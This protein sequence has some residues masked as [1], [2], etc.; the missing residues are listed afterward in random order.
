MDEHVI[1]HSSDD[2]EGAGYFYS[3]TENKS[4]LG[5][6]LI[7]MHYYDAGKEYPVFF[8]YYRKKDELAKWHKEEEFREKNEIARD[9]IERMCALPN[10]PST[11]LM[12][13]YFMT[14]ENV[15]ILKKHGK[16]YVS[17]PK[18]NWIATY[19]HKR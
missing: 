16:H 1:P 15:K 9:L 18:R 10:A 19:L 17:R 11:F 13:S 14:K 6:S 8:K 12:D 7:M 4:I 2:I 3:T 5:M